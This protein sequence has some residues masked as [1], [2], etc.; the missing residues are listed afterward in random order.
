MDG[1]TVGPPPSADLVGWSGPTRETVN[2]SVNVRTVTSPAALTNSRSNAPPEYESDPK[3]PSAGHAAENPAGFDEDDGEGDLAAADF[4]AET[5]DHRRPCGATPRAR[6]VFVQET[7][8]EATLRNA[9][10]DPVGIREI[11]VTVAAAR[12]ITIAVV[13]A[14]F[15]RRSR[16][17]CERATIERSVASD[18]GTSERARRW[19]SSPSS[20][21]IGRLLH[22]HPR[23]L[24]SLSTKPRQCSFAYGRARF[25][26]GTLS[27]RPEDDV[28]P[29]R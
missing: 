6:S 2:D 19:E 9:E 16:R 24:Y 29:A 5:A 25:S 10:D 4:E 12:A 13:V 8:L 11:P 17:R 7:A 18:A 20:I 15:S 22:S 21:V 28:R 14:I 27:A 26:D 1:T 23:D 3:Q